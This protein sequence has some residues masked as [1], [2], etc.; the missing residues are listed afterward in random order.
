M[1][2]DDVTAIIEAVRVRL[3]GVDHITRR[4]VLKALL[5]DSAFLALLAGGGAGILEPAP[6]GAQQRTSVSAAALRAA[7]P[8][9][10]FDRQRTVFTEGMQAWLDQMIQDILLQ[11]GDITGGKRVDPR[12]GRSEGYCGKETC[13]SD[14]CASDG[15]ND[16]ACGKDSC[17]E[18]GC[19]SN[20]CADTNTCGSDGCVDRNVCAERNTCTEQSCN[21][22][23]FVCPSN[24]SVGG[25]LSPGEFLRRYQKEPFVRELTELFG[26]NVERELQNMIVRGTT[27]RSR[28]LVGTGAP[29][30]LPARSFGDILSD[31]PGERLRRTPP[32]GPPPAAPKP[33]T[34]Q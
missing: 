9:R 25:W 13:E 14:G 15:C 3:S 16:N 19:A 23:S 4:E 34:P 31:L 28:G 7:P 20:G 30:P 29:P 1:E 10:A 12:T 5:R 2:R 26:R 17:N 11:I 8:D 32:T 22:G 24:T 6:A 27:L 18:N 33:R 21:P